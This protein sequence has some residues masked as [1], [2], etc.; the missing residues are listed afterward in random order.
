[1]S[2]DMAKSIGNNINYLLNKR[3]MNQ[4]DLSKILNVSEST[5][6][7]WILGKSIP[8]MGTIEKIAQYFGVNKSFILNSGK[9]DYTYDDYHDYLVNQRQYLSELSLTYSSGLDSFS[10]DELSLIRLW[11]ESSAEGQEAAKIVLMSH[12]K[13]LV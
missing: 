3:K 5:V 10:V 1:M 8:R 13:V 7:K 11:R 4:V 6:G 2:E 9:I 12:K